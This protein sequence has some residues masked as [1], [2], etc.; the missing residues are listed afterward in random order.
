MKK[1]ILFIGVLATPIVTA[2]ENPSFFVGVK[3]GYQ[4][5]DDQKYQSSNP[6]NSVYGIYSGIQ[7]SPAWSWDLGYQYHE[8][9]KAE[10]SSV[11]VNTWLV[12]SAVRYDWHFSEKFSLY[13]RVGV[14][15]WDM[16]KAVHSV[17]KIDGNGFSPVG[18]LGVNYT[19]NPNLRMSLG[20][21]Y[22]NSIGITN[23]G[24]YDSYG[25]L[26]GFT[27]TFGKTVKRNVV[28]RSAPYK[29]EEDLKVPVNTSPVVSE[30]VVS[31]VSE[32]AHDITSEEVRA[33]A[34]VESPEKLSL[35][36]ITFSSENIRD[37]FEFD[38]QELSAGFIKELSELAANLKRY[39]QSRVTIVGHTDSLSSAAYNQFLSE[40]RA[41]AVANKLLELGAAASQI[42]VTGAGE[43]RPIA[44]N[45]TAEGR[46]KNR[47]VVVTVSDFNS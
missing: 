13:G 46:R 8:K 20:Y 34:T 11:E 40:R 9:L 19:F 21:Q 28:H 14:A 30:E 44:D 43:T 36:E 17:E 38:S 25:A 10:A 31:I 15:Y 42:T 26:M 5:A 47:R 6:H 39:P 23:T 16:Q 22:I 37:S 45:N 2:A 12:E 29:I 33:S 41:Q 3:G 18:E 4:W 32:N 24:K 1:A 7:F 35:N 27:Y